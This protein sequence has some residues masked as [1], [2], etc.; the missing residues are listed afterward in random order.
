M[1]WYSLRCRSCDFHAETGYEDE[2][3]T[4]RRMHLNRNSIIS[5]PINWHQ[6]RITAY[7]PPITRQEALLP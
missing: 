2:A 5:D 6:I 4:L 3:R 1:T 7:K